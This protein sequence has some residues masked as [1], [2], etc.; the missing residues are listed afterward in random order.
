MQ[1]AS[2]FTSATMSPGEILTFGGATANLA[3]LLG[4]LANGNG[5]EKANS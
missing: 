1:A 4:E 5:Y 2:S 3:Y